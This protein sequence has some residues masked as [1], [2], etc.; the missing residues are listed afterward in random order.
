[1]RLGIDFGT[2]HTVVAAVD[3][4]NYPV[5]AFEWGD[6]FPSTIAI[7]EDSGEVLHGQQAEASVER[8]EWRVLRSFKRMLRAVGPEHEIRIGSHHFLVADLLAEHLAR[9]REA[10]VSE[11]NAGLRRRE[12]LTAAV[13]VPA[14]A[15]N[16]Q[17]FLTLDAFRR[18]GFDVVSLLNEPSA[19]GFEYGQRFE[20]TIT[21]RREHV[22]VYDLGGGTFDA[23]LIHMRGLANEVVQS[24]GLPDLGGTDFDD[25]ILALVIDAAQLR[26]L[27]AKER[28]A[29]RE[30]C[31]EQKERLTPNTRRFIVDL[32]RFGKDPLAIPI[33]KV[34]EV[35]D[36]L[37]DRTLG[38]LEDVLGRA[39]GGPAA[40]ELAG[41]YVVGGGSGWAP[42]PRR[43]R[44]LYGAQRVKRSTQPQA[45]TAIGLACH[46]DDEAGYRLTDCLTRSFGVWREAS[47]GAEITFDPIFERDTPLPARGD[48]PLEVVRRYRAAHNVGHFRY[49][50]CGALRD[51]GPFGQIVPWQGVHFPFEAAL[52]DQEDLS[53]HPVVRGGDGTGPEVEERYTCSS[54]GVFEA[55]LTCLED[56]YS[57]KFRLARPKAR[58][59]SSSPAD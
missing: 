2:T 21:S 40:G 31:R 14:H 25:A 58:R 36:A 10:L 59:R 42:I 20:R 23:S 5:V 38:V 37:V 6:A 53:E 12:K 39:G 4:G 34:Y 22:L 45:A 35:C 18:A 3:R 16:D 56:G 32:E 55:E 43:L 50:E 1:M 29:L 28:D 51:G 17:R 27:G 7:D 33:A 30:A 19:A 13:S 8:P 47:A 9:L 26:D 15:S 48:P 41:I 46:L 52:R 49:V 54:T 24:A 44:A 57:R 11:S